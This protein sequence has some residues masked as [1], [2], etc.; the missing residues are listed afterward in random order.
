MGKQ[1]SS[2]G[3]KAKAIG[4]E[5]D[6]SIGW[7]RLLQV[8]ATDI[9]GILVPGAY[10]LLLVA[11]VTAGVA[12]TADWTNWSRVGYIATRL[13]LPQVKAIEGGT[14]SQGPSFLLYLS[15]LIAAYIVGYVFYRQSPK[16]PDS[17]GFLRSYARF[18]GNDRKAWVAWPKPLP[19]PPGASQGEPETDAGGAPGE[20]TDKE[21]WWQRLLSWLDEHPR[22]LNFRPILCRLGLATRCE[23]AERACCQAL[24]SRGGLDPLRRLLGLL[25]RL[26]FEAVFL[27]ARAGDCWQVE[28]PYRGLARYLLARRMPTLARAVPWREDPQDRHPLNRSKHYI[29]RIKEWIRCELPSEYDT[30]ARNESHVRMVASM[31]YATRTALWLFLLY[32]FYGLLVAATG[33]QS[34]WYVG[35]PLLM[36]VVLGWIKVK[37]EVFIHYQRV[38]EIVTIMCMTEY[39]Q[40]RHGVTIWHEKLADEELAEEARDL[41]QALGY[42]NAKAAPPWLADLAEPAGTRAP[43]PR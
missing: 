15:M 7:Q 35:V 5:A 10:F 40:E 37:I 32:A 27:F 16:A 12:V 41:I 6:G 28:F 31:W 36:I 34:F 25:D 22:C 17:M 24:R 20:P 23:D 42:P 43:L 39:I 2:S 30:V 29:N 8:W 13:F 11:V 19:A 21:D 18:T 33:G 1:S 14:L 26:A 4:G 38:C 3:E 9:L